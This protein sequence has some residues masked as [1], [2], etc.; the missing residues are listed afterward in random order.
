MML[1]GCFAAPPSTG[2]GTG[3]SGQSGS[4]DGTDG[5][6]TS[7]DPGTDTGTDGFAGKPATFPGDIPLI[8]GD[9]VFGVD[10]GTGW[11]VVIPV[12]D[13]QA[14]YTEASTQLKAAGFEA[15]AESTAADGSFGVFKNDTYQVQVTAADTGDYGLAVSYV[16]ALLG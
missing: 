6:N 15:L 1:T 5:G 13:A 11:T 4:S 3:G 12:T 2:G 9:V 14:S 8:G 16:V 7:T 10:L